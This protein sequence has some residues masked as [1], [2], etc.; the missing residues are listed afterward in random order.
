MTVEGRLDGKVAL[1]TGAGNGIGRGI[2]RRFARE[3][4]HVVLADID[5]DA[6]NA[7]AAEIERLGA[8]GHFVETDVSDKD[9]VIAAVDEATSTYGRLD[10][11]VNDAMA[12]SPNVLLEHK[13]DAML[14]SVLKIGLWGTWWSMHA[15]FPWMREQGGGRIVNFYSVDSDAG[16][17]LH[18]DYNLTKAAIQSLTRSAAVEWARFNITVNAIAPVAKSCGYYALI[19]EQ[20]DMEAALDATVP[21]GHIGDP[22]N[23]IAPAAVFLASDDARYITG[24]TLNVDGGMHLQRY[25]SRPQDLSAFTCP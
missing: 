24:E 13:S 15:A 25:S 16:T 6:G 18:V 12:L 2:A 3:G 17:W 8:R 1:V 4:A 23:D 21:L 20:P 22:E 5:T 19:R 11:V 7:V 9:Q 10:I 14:E